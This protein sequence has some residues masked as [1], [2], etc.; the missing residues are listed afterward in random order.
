MTRFGNC[1]WCRSMIKTTR[2]SRP[3]YELSPDL[4]TRADPDSARDKQQSQNM[5]LDLVL[6]S[7]QYNDKVSA[8]RR[9][10]ERLLNRS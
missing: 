6:L 9:R 7:I 5:S 8:Y 10:Y 4:C 1:C 3:A 2:S